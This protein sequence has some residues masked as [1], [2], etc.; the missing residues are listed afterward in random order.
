MIGTY[1]E[2]PR[3]PECQGRIAPNHV[4][5]SRWKK[6]FVED[7]GLA[8]ATYQRSIMIWCET[9]RHAVHITEQRPGAPTVK[10]IHQDADPEGVALFIRR[11]ALGNGTVSRSK[12]KSSDPVI[13]EI[14]SP[15]THIDLFV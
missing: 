7:G 10:I 4:F 2:C 15:P 11:I 5:I 1:T 12:I 3:S 8:M 13:A 6:V 14:K 9:C